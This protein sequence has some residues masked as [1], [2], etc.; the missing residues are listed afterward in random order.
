[1]SAA[2][3]NLFLGIDIGAGA[4][5]IALLAKEKNDSMRLLKAVSYEYEESASEL[6]QKEQL[7]TIAVLL[8][9]FLRAGVLKN[10]FFIL[11]LVPVFIATG[12]FQSRFPPPK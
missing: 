2:K 7:A 10:R 4:L 8:K 9:K 5:K 11:R 3:K 12:F 1:M 6:D